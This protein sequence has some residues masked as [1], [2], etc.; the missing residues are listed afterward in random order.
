MTLSSLPGNDPGSGAPFGNNE[1]VVNWLDQF[2]PVGIFTVDRDLVLTGWNRWMSLHSGRPPEEILGRPLLELYPDLVQRKV[3]RYFHKALAGQPMIL[4]QRFHHYLIPMIPEGIRGDTKFMPQAASIS[5]LHTSRGIAGVIAYVE[6]VS[7]R[8]KREK[9]LEAQ[10]A[11]LKETM[12]ELKILQ[13]FLPICSYCKSIRDDEGAWRQL[14]EYIGK[15]A[16]VD[17]SH[18]ICPKC[19]KEHFP[20][21]DLYGEDD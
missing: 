15:H 4:S 10:I 7:E 14:E 19:A 12:A 2:S 6:D 1:G 17:F 18:G 3:D 13:G 9:E 16:D 20:D 8:M 5:P 11:R 21:L